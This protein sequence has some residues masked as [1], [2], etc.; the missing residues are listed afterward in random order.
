MNNT[1][2]LH[3]HFQPNENSQLPTLVFIHGLFGDMNNLGVIAKAFS[4]Q[5]SILRVDL[6]NHGNSFH[7]E[8]MDYQL[9]AQDLIRL[10]DH[11]QLNNLILIGHSMGGKTAMM[12]AALIPQRINKLIV[13][14]IAPINYDNQKHDNVFAGLFAVQQAM[15]DS[16]QQAKTILAQHIPQESVQQF[17]LKSFLPQ[18]LSQNENKFRFNLTALWQN[19]SLLMGWSKVK[20]NLPTLFI[21]GGLSDYI[22][23]EHSKEILT[24]FPQA[25]SFTINSCGHWL[26]AEKPEI[27]IRTIMRFLN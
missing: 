1:D 9:M 14:D 17:M 22:Q 13:M 12:T 10:F 11:L 15:P 3:Y 4:E 25:S 6:R 8:Q 18:G 7:C 20:V 2:L 26:H 27:V 19:Y 16:R 21:R 5:Y 23:E 24:Q